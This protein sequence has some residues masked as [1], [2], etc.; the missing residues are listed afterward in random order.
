MTEQK[1]PEVARDASDARSK[2]SL[3]EPAGETVQ[4][5]AEY[6]GLAD[7]DKAIRNRQLIGFLEE[8]SMPLRYIWYFAGSLVVF[9]A[10]AWFAVTLF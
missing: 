6:P 9:A 2:H 8:R 1:K 4:S 3:A 7:L 10:I 5:S